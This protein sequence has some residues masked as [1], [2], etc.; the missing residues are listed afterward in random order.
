MEEAIK[1]TLDAD[2]SITDSMPFAEAK[3]F[4]HAALIGVCK[5]LSSAQNI[6]VTNKSRTCIQLS[7][8]GRECAEKGSPEARV[9]AMIPP[10]GILQDELMAS[11]GNMAKVGMAK[12]V[13][14]KWLEVV[15]EEGGAPPAEDGKKVAPKKRVKRAVESVTDTVQTQLRAVL[16]ANGAED[17]LPAEELA[18]LKKRSL[19]SISTLKTVSIAKGPTFATWGQKAVADLTHE[20]LV[21]GTWKDV[22]FKPLNFNAAGK[23]PTGGALHPLMKVR[24]MFREIFFEMG[25]EEMRT[26]QFVESSFWNFDALFQ[27]QQHPARDE[28]DTFFMKTPAA[29]LK[30]PEDY[31][32]RVKATHENGGKD[33]DP[34]YASGS[35]GWQYDWSEDV[36][37]QNLLRTHT[38]AVSSRTLYEL[39][40]IAKNSNG[41][42]K[43]QK[44]FSI[45]RVFR[46]EALDATHLAEFHQVEG[47]VIGEGLSLSHLM[48]TIEDFY[49]RLGPEFQDLLFKPTYNPYTEP[50]MEF[51]CWHPT[52]KRMVE[53]GNS[54]V[55]RPEMLR[56]MGFPEGVSVIAWGMSLERPTMVKYKFKDIRALF[57]HRIDLNMTR[58]HPIVRWT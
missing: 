31:M 53:V 28:H 18:L 39:A 35:T 54:G 41:Q 19:L 7:A 37:R 38:T 30:V 8:E 11:A 44:Y 25:F 12:A 9:F 58:E 55:F 56:P 49:R 36:T 29:T 27:P 23:P 2:G 13:Q 33:L 24:S 16:A 47:F 48:G 4:D 34:S 50:S 3:G 42:I 52:L 45:D 57:G 6:E 51:H 5:S 22:A 1:A 43:P 14:G 15:K 21:K 40:Q 10:E 46:N 26:N 20:M 32:A 17:A